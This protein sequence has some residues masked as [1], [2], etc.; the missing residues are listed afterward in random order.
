MK[1]ASHAHQFD[2]PIQQKE[3]VMLGMWAFLVTEIMFFGGLFLGYT[4]YRCLY[5]QAFA[6]ASHHLDVSLGGL[7][8]AILLGSSLTMAFGV[9]AVK[10]GAPKKTTVFF[11]LA[12]VV[13][14]AAFLG[15]KAVEYSHK[16][17]EHFVPGPSFAAGEF[18]AR[19]SQI[20]FSFYFAMTGMHA[21]HMVIGIFLL[22]YLAW[23]AA[24]GDFSPSYDSPVETIGLYWHF[25]D[26]IWI[27]LFPLLYLIGRHH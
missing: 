5:P 6:A 1:H 24:K 26:I 22:L 10:A 7:N 18:A 9:N 17:H 14:G 2:D 19:E 16:F 13:L 25:V 27:F 12:T 4:V 8:T 21:V 20:F 3:S 15:I 23:R 11:L